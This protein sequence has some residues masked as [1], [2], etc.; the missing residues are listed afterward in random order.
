MTLRT[1]H[2]LA[3]LSLAAAAFCPPAL[4]AAGAEGA[5]GVRQVA[6]QAFTVALKQL[7]AFHEVGN[8]GG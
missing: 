2:L 4:A 1:P 7:K 8:A 5:D 6:P 3:A